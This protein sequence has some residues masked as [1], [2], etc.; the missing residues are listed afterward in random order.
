[1]F[2]N[3]LTANAVFRTS[4]LRNFFFPPNRTFDPLQECSKPYLLQSQRKKEVIK[5]KFQNTTSGNISL[6][7]FLSSRIG[8][9]NIWLPYWGGRGK[10]WEFLYLLQ[11]L[12]LPVKEGNHERMEN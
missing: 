8:I 4:L 5:Y 3:S 11:F 7:M 10:Y 6:K 12:F 2:Q 9:G 1:M